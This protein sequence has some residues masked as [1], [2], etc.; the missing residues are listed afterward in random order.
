LQAMEIL[1]RTLIIFRKFESLKNGTTVRSKVVGTSRCEVSAR[2]A[3]G[4]MHV[5]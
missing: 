3:G 1:P 5:K 4:R 2:K